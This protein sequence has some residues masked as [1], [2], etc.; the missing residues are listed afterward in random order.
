M[1]LYYQLHFIF[2]IR[3]TKRYLKKE[4]FHIAHK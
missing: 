1:F 4:K 2:E 3:F